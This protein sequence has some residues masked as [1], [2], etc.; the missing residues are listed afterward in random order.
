MN[1]DVAARDLHFHSEQSDEAVALVKKFHY[2]HRAPANVQF[3]GTFHVGGGLFGDFGPAIAAVFFSVPPTKW[4]EPVVELSRLVRDEA[5]RVPLT[6]LVAVACREVKRRGHDLV[7]SYADS[8]QGHHGGVY[9]ACS[10][11]YNGKRAAAMDGVL[12]AGKFFPGRTCN[13]VY[14]TRSPEK[15]AAL[16]GTEVLPH[17]DGGK[18]LYWKP[19]SRAGTKKAA[20]LGLVSVPYPK[21]DEQQFDNCEVR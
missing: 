21:P 13:S 1:T 17:Y 20:R 3:V 16:L 15:L 5:C 19:L 6:K 8:T 4:A 7:V 12:I 2:S 11:N 14:G 9:Q 10:W 18:H